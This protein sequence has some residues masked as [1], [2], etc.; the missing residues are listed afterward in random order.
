MASVS[1][2]QKRISTIGS[3]FCQFGAR[4]ESGETVRRAVPSLFEILV[5]LSPV[6][7]TS[8]TQKPKNWS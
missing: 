2:F 7:V 6:K 1:K 8:W 3:K 4:N 5:T